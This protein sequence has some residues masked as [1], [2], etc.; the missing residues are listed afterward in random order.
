MSR[1]IQDNNEKL[2]TIFTKRQPN[3]TR[4]TENSAINAI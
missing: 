4:R 1:K 2:E 3:N